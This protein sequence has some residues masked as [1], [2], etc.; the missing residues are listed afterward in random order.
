MRFRLF[1]GAC[2]LALAATGCANT[3]AGIT[4]SVKN[5]LVADDLV[6]A[7]QIDVDTRDKV[8]TLTGQVTTAEEETR[9]LQIA[10]GTEGVVDV[11]DQIEIVVPQASGF[12]AP[13]PTPAP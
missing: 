3:D 1:V 5:K 9:A 12:P 7:R 11:I 2:A 10:R 4:T 8:V 6:K 13:L